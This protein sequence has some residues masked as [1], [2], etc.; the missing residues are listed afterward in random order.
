MVGMDVMFGMVGMLDSVIRR[1]SGFGLGPVVTRRVMVGGLC[2]DEQ[3]TTILGPARQQGHQIGGHH[4]P[5]AGEGQPRRGS[6]LL[7]GWVVVVRQVV[8]A[9]ALW[10]DKAAMD[11]GRRIGRACENRMTVGRR[12]KGE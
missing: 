6:A 8:H 3:I 1:R 12:V 4:E 5:D 11:G 9:R 7:S 2:R 10:Q